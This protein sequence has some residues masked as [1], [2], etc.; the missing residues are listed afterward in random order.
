MNHFTYTIW[1]QLIYS[2]FQTFHTFIFGTFWCWHFHTFTCVHFE[3]RAIY[4]V[5][6]RCSIDTFIQVENVSIFL[7]H[8]LSL[9]IS[10]SP[11]PSCR[12]SVHLHSLARG[13]SA[14]QLLLLLPL[15]Q[16]P[17]C[18]SWVTWLDGALTPS[19]SSGYVIW[20][21]GRAGTMQLRTLATGWTQEFYQEGGE[22]SRDPQQPETRREC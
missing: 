5:F 12:L 18:S 10:I 11:A 14:A 17:T 21:L 1:K 4:G 22:Q 9:S 13:C 15:L 16:A 2:Y 8:S 7:Q 20:R 3:F 6:L 19:S